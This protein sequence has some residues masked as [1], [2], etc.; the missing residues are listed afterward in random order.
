[1]S[2][3]LLQEKIRKMK[4]PSVVDMTATADMIPQEVLN[5]M[6]TFCMLMMRFAG[7]FWIA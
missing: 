2:V 3:D 6:R 1:M 4:N 7:G 5:A